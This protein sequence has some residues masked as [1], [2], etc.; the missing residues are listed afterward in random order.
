MPDDEAAV[1]AA[2]PA[3]WAAWLACAWL[4]PRALVVFAFF[5]PCALVLLVAFAFALDPL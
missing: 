3:A 4:T 2:V 1:F 5:A